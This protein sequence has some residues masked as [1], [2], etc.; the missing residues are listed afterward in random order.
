MRTHL[1]RMEPTRI[2][3]AVQAIGAGHD[4]VFMG[5]PHRVFPATLVRSQVLSNNLGRTFLPEDAFTPEWAA[6][7]ND[8]PVL[9]LHPEKRGHPVSA[10]DPDILNASGIGRLLRVRA[11]NGTLRGDV[12]IDSE[13][14][15]AVPDLKVILGKLDRNETAELSTGFPVSVEETAGVHNGRDYDRVIRP[16]GA[17]D[18]LAVFAEQTGACSVKDGCGLGVNHAGDC[19]AMGEGDVADPQPGRLKLL[20]DQVLAFL[21]KNN[22]IPTPEAGDDSTQE[23]H[24]MDRNQMIASLVANGLCKDDLAKLSDDSIKAMHAMAK[25]T[26]ADNSDPDVLSILQ[27]RNAELRKQ[28]EDKEAATKTAVLAE[29]E[30]LLQKQEDLIFNG[31][32]GF[33]P[34]EIRV[35]DITLTRKL[36]DTV[37]RRADYSARGGPRSSS[38]ALNWTPQDVFAADRKEAN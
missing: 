30:E 17:G 34:E 37:F 19:A 15:S 26:T 6:S 33:T 35:M 31:N 29:K 23:G 9:T 36:Y 14:A 8:A 38:A 2:E 12:F 25:P 24:T 5:R 11:E 18:H 28:L 4:E 27:R 32:T 13:R 21:K 10:R 1:V 20:A 16:I 3:F 7:W 22:A